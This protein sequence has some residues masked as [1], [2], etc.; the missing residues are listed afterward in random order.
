MAKTIEIKNF[1][2]DDGSIIGIGNLSTGCIYRC[3][4]EGFIVVVGEFKPMKASTGLSKHHWCNVI[5]IDPSNSDYGFFHANGPVWDEDAF[6]LLPS[7][8][9]VSLLNRG[10]GA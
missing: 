4:R 9:A 3:H 7:E 1:R 6:D 5:V 10:V 2:Q 8:V